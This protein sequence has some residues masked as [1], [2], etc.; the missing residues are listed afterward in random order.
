MIRGAV[1]FLVYM[2][3]VGGLVACH[4]NIIS[5]ESGFRDSASISPFLAGPAPELRMLTNS[6]Y[7][8]SVSELAGQPINASLIASW[9]PSDV[10]YDFDSVAAASLDEKTITDRINAAESLVP[11]LLS[12]KQVMSCSPSNPASTLEDPCIDQIFLNFA[13]RAYR[14]PLDSLQMGQL[15]TVFD[16]ARAASLANFGAT[17]IGN[18]DG[19][20]SDLLMYGWAL[21]PDYDT[22]NVEVH[23]YVDGAAGA[24]GT[25]AGNTL[26]DQPR[27]DVNKVV[28]N[29]AGN[30]VSGDHGFVYQLPA[31]YADGRSHSVY[32]YAIVQPGGSNP[33]LNPL[34]KMFISTAAGANPNLVHYSTPIKEGIGAAFA[35]ILSSP[36]FLLKM[37]NPSTPDGELDD[38]QLAAR[39]AFTLTGSL[40]D[41]EL[42]R[43]AAEGLLHNPN[44]MQF[45]ADRL[46]NKNPDW[47]PSNFAGQWLGFRALQL[48]Y[49]QSPATD[50]T[51]L[52]EQ[53]MAQESQLMF[54]D[55][56]ANNMT[57]EQ[58]LRPGYTYI[59][60]RLANNYGLASPSSNA[61][62]FV[63]VESADRGG[64]IEQA[65]FL[66][67]TSKPTESFPIR[68]G[69]YIRG[70]FLCQEI[71][72]P[73]A[74]L[75]NTIATVIANTPANLS[76]VGQMAY[77][78]N[79]SPICASCHSQMDPVGLGLE[80]YDAFGAW[81]THYL[82]GSPVISSSNLDGSNFSSGSSLS[83]LLQNSFEYR[84]CVVKK[85]ATYI[86][87]REMGPND[88]KMI[89]SLASPDRSLRDIFMAIINSDAFKKVQVEQ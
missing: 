25:F 41:P 45:Q 63:K 88:N 9:N 66:R 12:S 70:E 74:N 60:S 79:A 84:M 24:G 59:N 3:M 57:L 50:S 81:R 58:I 71:P 20:G 33:V 8:A 10:A 56:F 19:A 77:H 55:I 7:L 53:D 83:S 62:N 89:L 54:E 51:S 16:T 4:L 80:N 65:S 64:A 32:A 75:M 23:F 15:K 28:L 26:A 86:L 72:A 34:P 49:Q 42:T 52:L 13:A 61:N 18:F 40:P 2:L 48:K 17:A 43:V 1:Q 36:E 31:N 5:A 87:S 29:S 69:R 76:V 11:T 35:A 82:D 78:R 27:P 38:Y 22:R 85:A 39:L 14:R 6:E 44:Q 67:I 21:D 30:Y 37:D 73:P 47:L 46:M 68:R